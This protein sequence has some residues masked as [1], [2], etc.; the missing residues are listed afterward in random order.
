MEKNLHDIDRLF[1]SFLKGYEEEPADNVWA[2]IENDLNRA[3]AE[4]YKAKYK[5]LRRTVA[6]IALLLTSLLLMDIVQT[7]NYNLKGNNT[8]IKGLKVRSSTEKNAVENKS[9]NKIPNHAYVTKP[10]NDNLYALRKDILNNDIGK[11]VNKIF[12]DDKL[13]NHNPVQ[14]IDSLIAFNKKNKTL[15]LWNFTHI[16]C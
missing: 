9:N 3:D 10:V 6:C 2:S 14:P 16:Q 5:F 12:Q 11:G 7:Y 4:K 15:S 1:Q 13:Y 8:G